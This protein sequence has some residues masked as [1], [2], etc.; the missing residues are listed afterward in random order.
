MA[1]LGNGLTHAER[2]ADTLVVREAELATL[3][4]V[5]ASE[6]S[7]LAMQSNLANTYAHLGQLEEA[8]RLRRAVYSGSLRLYGEQHEETTIDAYNYANDLLEAN[9]FAEAKALLRK[10]MPVARRV[11]GE[12]SETTLRM[13]WNYASSL[14]AAPGAP[15]DDLREAVATLE[16]IEP[17]ARRVL[18]GAHPFVVETE[19]SLVQSRS[20]L[21]ASEASEPGDVNSTC[22]AVEAIALK[23]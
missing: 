16:D 11:L 8:L 20:V 9:R 2:H 21:R 22:A 12:G 19:R 17:I 18:G 13:R 14:F 15:L 1:E 23:E 7:M 3:R 4:R 5:G 10:T 6:R